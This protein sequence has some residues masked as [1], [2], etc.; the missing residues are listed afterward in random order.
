[1]A[2][3]KNVI[4]IGAGGSIGTSIFS[5]LVAST[6]FT[7]SVL[8]RPESTASYGP[9]IKVFKSDYSETSLAA[10]FK[11]QDAVVSALGAA[12][13]GEQLKI[14]D[15]AAKAGVQRYLPSEYGCDTQN[16][17][18]T[19]LVPAFGFKVDVIEYL[20]KVEARGLSWTAIETG[21]AFDWGL[22][23]GL[24]GFNINTHEA[25]IMDGGNRP[26]SAT[27]LSQIGNAVVAV[28]SKPAETANQFLYV[29][30][31]TATQNQI[32]AE[33]EKATGRKWAVTESSTEA[34]AR[35]GKELFGRG[36]FE[37]LLLLL[38]A[39]ML[40]E[41]FGSDFTEDERLANEM[42]GLPEQGLIET[43]AALVK[44]ESV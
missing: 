2:P 23:M 30:S 22:Q 34:A 10:A 19:S 36:D 21:P 43:V 27:N 16:E 7:V 3:I 44:G 4:V 28:L 42:L 14:I 11:G 8:T 32:L 33:L 20:R 37:G 40:G 31:F 15:A 26:F 38:K 5:A 24:V 9:N 6:K 13:M 17:K 35:E 39:V 29:D 1:M 12:G 41:G 25:L 18:A